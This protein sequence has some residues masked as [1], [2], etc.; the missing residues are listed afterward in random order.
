MSHFLYIHP[1]MAGT[2]N[3]WKV[4]VSKTPYS[5]VRGRQK[6]TWA[7][8][9]LTHLYFGVPS[10]IL[11]LEQEVKDH[12]RNCSRKLLQGYGTEIFEVD[13][14]QLQKCI[15]DT[16]VEGNLNVIPID[17]YEPYTAASSGQCPFGIPGEKEADWYLEQ[18]CNEIFANKPKKS[19]LGARN[20]FRKI[21]H[22]E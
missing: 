12:Y 20:T 17:L 5:A 1:C 2:P 4:G 7:K 6:Y 15:S 3:V 8:F 21:F 16:I 18:K 19:K 13:I 10:H 9:G 22:Y 14:I 11:W